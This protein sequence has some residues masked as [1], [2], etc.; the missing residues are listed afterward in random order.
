[1]QKLLEATED[2]RWLPQMR[3]ALVQ[4]CYE[5]LPQEGHAA[6]LAHVRGGLSPCELMLLSAKLGHPRTV[7][8]YRGARARISLRLW[9]ANDAAFATRVLKLDCKLAR[10]GT[11]CTPVTTV[12]K[13]R[14]K[15]CSRGK[16]CSQVAGR[17]LDAQ[18]MLQ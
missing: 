3:I 13:P 6:A 16:V 1:V 5:A 4:A 2:A 18:Y 8:P 10:A 12:K 15:C 9:D 11:R 7:D 17:A 14:P